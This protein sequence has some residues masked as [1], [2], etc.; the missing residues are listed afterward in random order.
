[1][2]TSSIRFAALVAV[3]GFAIVNNPAAAQ[4]S[5]EQ[6][7]NVVG[8]TPPGYYRGIPGMQDNEPSCAFNPLLVRNIVCA[9]NA[10][11]GANDLIQ[12]TWIAQSVTEHK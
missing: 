4:S 7:S 2:N 11:G 8:V 12:D 9:W 10:S 5:V 3:L 6:N 1:M